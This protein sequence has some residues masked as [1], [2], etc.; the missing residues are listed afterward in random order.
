MLAR[1]WQ[2]GELAGEDAGSPVDLSITTEAAPLSRIR[3]GPPQAPVHPYA[4]S[5]APLESTV[6]AESVR[7]TD[8]GLAAEAGLH[9]LRMLRGSGA[10]ASALVSAY[11]LAIPAPPDPAG[12]PAG[13]HAHQLLAGMVPDARTMAA[14]LRGPH[15]STFAARLGVPQPRQA[16]V[17]AIA[18]GWLAWYDAL[19]LEPGATT[20]S[21]SPAWDD[22]RLEHRFGVSAVH[23]AGGLT[24]EATRYRD[25]ELDWPDLDVGAADGLGTVFGLPAPLGR[26]ERLLPTAVRFAGMPAR[27]FWEIEDTAVS[28]AGLDAGLTDVGRVLLSEFGL[29]YGN[30]WYA[31][32]VSVPL[33]ALLAVGPVAVTDTFGVT[34]VLTRFPRTEA[35]A[36]P[37]SLAEFAA[38]D[39]LPAR[40]REVVAMLPS[41]IATL[42]GDPIERVEFGRDE[43][44]NLVWAVEHIVTGAA[45]TLVDRSAEVAT[46]PAPRPADPGPATLAYRLASPVPANW[47]AYVPTQ[48]P[49]QAPGVTQLNRQV[50]PG[51][52]ARVT[53]ESAIVEEAEI[54][55][56]GIVVERSWQLAR[57]VDGRTVLWVGRRVTSSAGPVASGLAW[58]RTVS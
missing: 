44:A 24:L 1:Q 57:W 47:V 10:A 23:T 18:A 25:G 8:A 36:R 15:G 55:A 6:E 50:T 29:V 53:A 42:R 5:A 7:D 11:P 37:W 52:R 45:G 13:T 54:P 22:R 35:G 33:G 28:F 41:P 38:A 17:Q 9:A 27:R 3:L 30:D 34:S 49:G 39:A 2:F 58:D 43:M 46:T 51:S 48:V 4:P 16:A 21:A 20:V 14:D 19:V 31:A 32:P 40:V 26:T 56:G 12:D